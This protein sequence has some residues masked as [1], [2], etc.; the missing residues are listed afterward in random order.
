MNNS[1]RMLQLLSCFLILF[2][3][4]GCTDERK[5]KLE[6]GVGFVRS[7]TNANPANSLAAAHYQADTPEGMVMLYH[8]SLPADG[9]YPN[10]YSDR[11]SLQSW[12]LLVLPGNKVRSL[13]IEG[14][15]DDLTKPLIVEEIIFK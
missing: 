4:F 8:S 12:S 5:T 6:K 13:I 14:Y 7:L 10:I 1:K 15:G 9:S 2:F 3:V 11:Q